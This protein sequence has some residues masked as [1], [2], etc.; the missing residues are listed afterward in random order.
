ML[1]SL[2]YFLVG[3]V[4]GTGQRPNEGREIELLVLRHQVRVL[5]RQV[6]R[7]RLRRLDRLLLAAASKAMPRGQ[8]SSF[9]VRPETL[10]R[11]HRELV[12]RKWTYKRGATP[13]GHRSTPRSARSSSGW[14]GRIPGGA[15][16]ASAESC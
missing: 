14:V 11:W 1:F 13:A 4:L 16:S 8:W 2:V 15:T 12:G 3:R 5:Q 9:V 6:K 10:L 7:P